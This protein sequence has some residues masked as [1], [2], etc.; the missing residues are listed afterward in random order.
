M[1]LRHIRY[2][3]A[4]AETLNFTRAAERLEMSQPGMS[5]ALARLREL[6][7]DPLLVRSGNGFI[8]TERALSLAE[9]VRGGVPTE[10]SST[11]CF[12]KSGACSFCSCLMSCAGD[13]FRRAS[14][15][16]FFSM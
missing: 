1:E 9:K 8:L 3:E 6:I 5:N 13:S 14:F 12:E 15:C 11:R 10:S 7:G 16:D 2:F 4:L